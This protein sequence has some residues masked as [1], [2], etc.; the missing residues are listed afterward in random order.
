MKVQKKDEKSFPII[1]FHQE[2]LTCPAEKRTYRTW[3]HT[4][5]KNFKHGHQNQGDGGSWA[6]VLPQGEMQ[7]VFNN[8]L[9]ETS[10]ILK[11]SFQKGTNY[12]FIYTYA[13]TSKPAKK[14]EKKKHPAGSKNNLSKSPTNQ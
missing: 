13:P 10:H 9:M 1:H 7:L 2:P 5:I 12:N 6:W 8:V 14:V 11:D 4:C 3:S